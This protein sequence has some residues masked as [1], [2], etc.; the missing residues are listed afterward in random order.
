MF[1]DQNFLAF[2]LFIIPQATALHCHWYFFN[3]WVRI[4]ILFITKFFRTL[5]NV[6]KMTAGIIS[7]FLQSDWGKQKNYLL[8]Q[9]VLKIT[10]DSK[11]MNTKPNEGY[12]IAKNTLWKWILWVLNISYAPLRTHFSHY[13]ASSVPSKLVLCSCFILLLYC[14]KIDVG[15]WSFA[16]G[17]LSITHLYFVAIHSAEILD[18]FKMVCFQL[19]LDQNYVNTVIHWKSSFDFN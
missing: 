13:I 17:Q 14:G 11:W 8:L 3:I 5:F 12:R 2:K 10:Y 4:F 1:H 9:K 15:N 19:S 18:R 16:F 6:H 7:K